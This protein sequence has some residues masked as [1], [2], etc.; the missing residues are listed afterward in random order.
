MTGDAPDG[1]GTESAT[2]SSV[3]SG[4]G[5]T[6]VGTEV[7]VAVAAETVVTPMEEAGEVG[8]ESFLKVF[9]SFARLFWNHTCF[10]K[11]DEV[12]YSSVEEGKERRTRVKEGEK[13][14]KGRERERDG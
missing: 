13:K 7:V 14:R 8:D 10:V 3:A 4:D 5:E 12:R 1:G 2:T 6:S 11:R 9:F